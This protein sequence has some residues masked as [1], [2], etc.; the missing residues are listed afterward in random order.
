MLRYPSYESSV[1]TLLKRTGPLGITDFLE[2]MPGIPRTTV[3]ARVR[4]LEQ[5]GRI[6]RIGKGKY[7]SAP[8]PRYQATPSPWMR[9]VFSVLT[10]ECIGLYFCIKEKE[11][12]LEVRVEK[13]GVCQVLSCLRKRYAKVVSFA[14]AIRFPAP[15]EGYII[16]GHL[17]SEAPVFQADGLV[18]PSLEMD[19]VDTVCTSLRRKEGFPSSS[20]QKALEVYPVNMNK[21]I[22]YASRRGVAEEVSIGLGGLNRRRMEMFSAVQNYLAST[23]ITRAWVFGSY[24]RGEET[25]ESDLDLLVDY[26]KTGGVSLLTIVRYKL[27]LEQLLGKKVDLVENGYLK[28]F[29]LPSAERD[30]YLVYER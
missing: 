11:G 24:A 3:N 10:E 14:D 4:A 15:L 9:E 29:A 19:L 28:P 12:N 30:K 1:A 21:L 7:L 20:F 26:D 16:V 6:V 13:L 8:K 23:K 2:A 25:T 5:R 22:R 18:V 27:D 17:I